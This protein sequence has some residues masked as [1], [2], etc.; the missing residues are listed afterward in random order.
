MKSNTNQ[1]ALVRRCD[2]C[3]M[4]NAC[5]LEATPARWMELQLPDHTVTKVTEAEA[6]ELWKN[7]GRCDHKKYIE[8][9]RAKINNQSPNTTTR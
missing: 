7:A 3:G 1:S 6:L 2:V 5:D 9:L 4:I 8:D